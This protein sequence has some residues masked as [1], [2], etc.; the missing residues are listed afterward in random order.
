MRCATVL[1]ALTAAT[2][3]APSLAYVIVLIGLCPT[4]DSAL[5]LSL[6]IQAREESD[7]DLFARE[8]DNEVFARTLGTHGEIGRKGGPRQVGSLPH[9]PKL[10]GRDLDEELFART[11]GTHGENGRKGGPRQV[12]S[13]PHKPKLDGR[14]FDEELFVRTLGSHGEIGRKGGPRQVGS[15]PHKPK[16][17]GRDLE[18]TYNLWERMDLEELE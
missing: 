4:S 5:F 15:L 12:G 6:P 7:L 13:L 2:A 3:V 8:L 18:D 16:L 10:D 9:K 11:L 1:A 14:D 17:D